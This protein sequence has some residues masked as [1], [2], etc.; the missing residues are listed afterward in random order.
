MSLRKTGKTILL[1]VFIMF[2]C[3]VCQNRPPTGEKDQESAESKADQIL[4]QASEYISGLKSFTAELDMIMNVEAQGM[5][6]EMTSNYSLALQ[7]P[8]KL[9]V[10]MNS[11]M[12]GGTLV[13]DGKNVYTYTPMT[14]SFTTE[15]APESLRD[16]DNLKGNSVMEMTGI[17]N[18]LIDENPYDLIS[19]GIKNMQYVGLE[20][21][22]DMKL[23]HLKMT[24]D[25]ED[26]ETDLDVW[27]NEG[28]KTLVHKI[29]PDVAEVLKRSGQE[30][31]GFQDMKM[32]VEL[33][34]KNWEVNKNIPDDT[35]VFS[36]PEGAE[37]AKPAGPHPLIGKP[38]PSFKLELLE[39]GDFD[40]SQQKDKNI[41]ILD[42]WATWCGPCKKVMPI[43]EE[44]AE[45]YQDKGVVVI[46][47]DLR[48]EPEKIRT[49]LEEQ[50]LHPTVA[51]DKDGKVGSLYEAKS[52]P[53]T[54]IIGTDG[55]VQAVYVGTISTTKE[56]LKKELDDLLEEKK[57]AP[58]KN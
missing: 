28:K 43:I 36:P 11:G 20:D 21:S 54:V 4:R 3:W 10:I 17:V 48:E 55:T 56:A 32:D 8:N 57:L 19:E 31:P 33:V 1:G 41:V 18:V 26:E 37:L 9:A 22:N 50:G 35:F 49:F 42:F 16:L 38:A 30:M 25:L 6:Q 29:I 46:A 52:I 40:L 23:H 34:F 58:G 14:R 27:I 7:R 15:K 2:A 51:L 12:L 45:E 24:A 53:Q 13:C 47:V 39:G 5:K 44:I